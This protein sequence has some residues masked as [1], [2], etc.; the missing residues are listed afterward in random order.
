MRII[1]ELN[2]KEFENYIMLRLYEMPKYVHTTI[3]LD[4]ISYVTQPYG[5]ELH[6]SVWMDNGTEFRV[7]DN[8]NSPRYLDRD[9]FIR[10]WAGE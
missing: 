10:L 4:K 8:S 6:Y 2:D 5:A 1:W 3:D 7:S 9:T